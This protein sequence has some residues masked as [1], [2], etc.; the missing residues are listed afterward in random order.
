MKFIRVAC[1]NM[2]LFAPITL[3]GGSLF[4][5]N[6]HT[7]LA[8]ETKPD[9]KAPKTPQ[10]DSVI[11]SNNNINTLI[12]L[13]QQCGIMYIRVQSQP[14]LPR[15]RFTPHYPFPPAAKP[16]SHLPDRKLLLRAS[17]YVLF[18]MHSLSK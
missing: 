17:F 6:I 14:H 13:Q 11:L 16:R 10:F 15:L 18:T 4:A 3:A 1:E 2:C 9:E 7:S 5:L 8:V 12:T